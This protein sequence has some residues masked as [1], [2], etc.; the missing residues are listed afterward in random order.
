MLTLTPVTIR[1]AKEYVTEHHRHHKAP[2]GALFA[3]GVSSGDHL[4]G[5]AIIGRPVA[6]NNQDG[7]T[8]EVTRLCTNGAQNACSILYGA[9]RRVAKALGYKRLITYTLEVESGVSLKAAGWS[10]D[11]VSPGGSWSTD[12][13]PRE[14]NHPLGPKVR[15]KANLGGSTNGNL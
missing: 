13:R 3:I 6:R 11:K 8:A 5:V 2:T 10:P 12:S 15:W 14:D 7:Y 4:V 9:A 1:R